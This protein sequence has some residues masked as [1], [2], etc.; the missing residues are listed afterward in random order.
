MNSPRYGDYVKLRT[1]IDGASTKCLGLVREKKIGKITNLENSWAT[2]ETI[3]PHKISIYRLEQ[4]EKFIQPPVVG[5]APTVNVPAGPHKTKLFH[6]MSELTSILTMLLNVKEILNNE[7]NRQK[8]IRNL[9]NLPDPVAVRKVDFLETQLKNIKLKE[10]YI[11]ELLSTG[12]DTKNQHNF[13]ASFYP[14]VKMTYASISIEMN[15]EIER[16]KSFVRGLKSEL[17]L[18]GILKSVVLDGGKTRRNRRNRRKTLKAP[19]RH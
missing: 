10:N 6:D 1:D 9:G 17:L 15:K 4:L 19:S 5:P 18:K 3:N 8:R 14:N 12:R 7:F 16:V 13:K 11:N 2:V